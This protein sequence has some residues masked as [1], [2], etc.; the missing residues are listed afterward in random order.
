[1]K[2]IILN[3]KSDFRFDKHNSEEFLLIT[4]KKFVFSLNF[5][6]LIFKNFLICLKFFLLQDQNFQISFYVK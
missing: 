3:Y 2:I 1:M 4:I 5:I 6:K